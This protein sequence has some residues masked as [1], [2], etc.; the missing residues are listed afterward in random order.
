MRRA[1]KHTL[2]GTGIGAG[3]AA[4][5]SDRFRSVPKVDADLSE[6]GITYPPS[7]GWSPPARNEMWRSL[8]DDDQGTSQDRDFFLLL[9]SLRLSR[10]RR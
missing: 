4:V 3:L 7:P 2:I 8:R 5:F 1:F 6:L 10:F 9:F